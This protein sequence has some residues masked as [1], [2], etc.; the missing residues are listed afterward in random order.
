MT[1][2]RIATYTG[3]VLFANMNNIAIKLVGVS[4][5]YEI[6]HEKPTLVEKFMKGRN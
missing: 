5:K 3:V 6:H 1:I 2:K 4:K